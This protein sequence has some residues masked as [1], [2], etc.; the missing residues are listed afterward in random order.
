MTRDVTGRRTE[1][2]PA[3]TAVGAAVEMDV[4]VG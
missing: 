4:V 1:P 2:D 3:R